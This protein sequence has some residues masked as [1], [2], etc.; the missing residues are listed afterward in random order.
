MKKL[1]SSPAFFFEF[2]L[3]ITRVTERKSRTMSQMNANPIA[4]VPLSKAVVVE[5][6]ENGPDEQDQEGNCHHNHFLTLL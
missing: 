3:Q 6:M 5:S 1:G 4:G 2:T